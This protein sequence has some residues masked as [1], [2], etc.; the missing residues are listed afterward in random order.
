MSSQQSW[1]TEAMN[2][3]AMKSEL[4]HCFNFFVIVNVSDSERYDI[5]GPIRSIKMYS[6]AQ[7][8]VQERLVCSGGVPC[9]AQEEQPPP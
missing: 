2:D 6:Y 4:L 7:C 8:T 9:L 3:K 1:A 5:S